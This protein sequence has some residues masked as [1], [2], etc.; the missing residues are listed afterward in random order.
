MQGYQKLM[1][2][3]EFPFI[4]ENGSAIYT[5]NSYFNLNLVEKAGKY[6][7]YKLGKTYSEI[8]HFLE[9]TSAKFNH[10]ILGFHNTDKSEIIKKTQLS[11]EAV[12]LAMQREYSVPVFYD[13]YSKDILEKEVKAYNLQ[14]LFGGRFMHILGCTDKGKALN[15]VKQ[16]FEQKFNS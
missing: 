1:G 14:I 16:G 4:V 9:S 12:D 3:E 5:F 8:V 2:I 13:D 10:N 6:D 7:C 11:P 15:L